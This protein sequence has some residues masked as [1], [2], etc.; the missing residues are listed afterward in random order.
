MKFGLSV[1]CY[2]WICYPP[3]PHDNQ[4]AM[5]FNVTHPAFLNMGWPLPHANTLRSPKPGEEKKWIVDKTAELGL[6]PLYLSCTWFPE[7]AEAEKTRAYAEEKGIALPAF[8]CY[9]RSVAQDPVTSQHSRQRQR[10]PT[11]PNPPKHSTA[12]LSRSRQP[13]AAGTFSG[14]FQE[15]RHE[16]QAPFRPVWYTG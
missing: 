11:W 8:C 14:I 6:S 3:T 16:I 5:V 4:G 2:R 15:E 9:N 1:A 12:Q 7:E 13:A 10:G